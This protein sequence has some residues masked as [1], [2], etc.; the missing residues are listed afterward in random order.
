MS[1]TR[2]EQT[3]IYDLEDEIP[4]KIFV[5]KELQKVT[6]DAISSRIN[7]NKKTVLL[8][9]KRLEVFISKMEKDIEEYAE[10]G[11]YEVE[12]DFKS[13]KVTVE[14]LEQCSREFKSRHPGFFQIVNRGK[15]TIKIS[16]HPSF[17]TK[18]K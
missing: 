18:N 4:E 6:K 9:R 17:S 3:I 5:I 2:E 1:E 10:S 14:Q 15:L 8:N 11:L 7:K 16:W 13:L 12:W